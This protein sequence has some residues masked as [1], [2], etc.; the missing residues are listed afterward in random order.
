MSA[1]DIMADSCIH[2]RKVCGENNHDHQSSLVPI[3]HLPCSAVFG[4]TN[5]NPTQCGFFGWEPSFL[6]TVSPCVDTVLRLA[7]HL[8]R[9][10]ERRNTRGTIANL[11]Q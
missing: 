2:G 4:G 10:T 7:G 5:T 6:S 1:H 3:T 9:D 11:Y 8:V